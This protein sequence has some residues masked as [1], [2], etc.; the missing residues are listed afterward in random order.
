VFI[1]DDDVFCYFSLH[2]NQG[3]F[4]KFKNSPLTILILL[5]LSAASSFAQDSSQTYYRCRVQ[6]Q[7]VTY[8]TR[9]EAHFGLYEPAWSDIFFKDTY[10]LTN[11]IGNYIARNE[12][13]ET[14]VIEAVLFNGGR[15]D[16]KNENLE[17]AQ[18]ALDVLKS[19]GVC[20]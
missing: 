20:R 2:P 1:A 8:D 14:K 5:S 13:G 19:Q 18:A 12:V 4:M 16:S 9:G 17:T 7:K 11:V 3:V 10:Y 6:N 15:S